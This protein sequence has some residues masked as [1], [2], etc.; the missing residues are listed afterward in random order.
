VGRPC[1]LCQHAEREA[2]TKDLL[3]GISYREISK[4]YAVSLGSLSAH[5]N[6]HIAGPV[7]RIIQA[8]NNLAQDCLTVEPVLVQM[9]R[10]NNHVLRVLTIA[11]ASKD[12]ELVLAAVKEARENLGMIA[13]ITGELVP[14]PLVQSNAPLQVNIVYEKRPLPDWNTKPVVDTQPV[15]DA[16][17]APES[18]AV[19][20]H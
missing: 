11:E 10:L 14:A 19:A 16:L 12:H 15:V 3:A 6:R 18:E 13:K 2:V 1:S 4:R 17:P 9:R 20:N 5:L 8:E 7:R